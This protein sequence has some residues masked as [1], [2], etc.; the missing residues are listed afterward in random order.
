MTRSLLSF[1]SLLTV[2]VERYYNR[3]QVMG[4][5]NAEM[6]SR[7]WW[8]LSDMSWLTWAGKVCALHSQCGLQAVLRRANLLVVGQAQAAQ[9]WRTQQAAACL[10]KVLV[11]E[12]MPPAWTCLYLK[13]LVL[14]TSYWDT[15]TQNRWWTLDLVSVRDLIIGCLG[16]SRQNFEN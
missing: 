9:C 7:K 10:D 3:L 5:G 6:L 11:P 2:S 16:K 15:G 4:Q 1:P 8:G 12:L 14:I 13:A